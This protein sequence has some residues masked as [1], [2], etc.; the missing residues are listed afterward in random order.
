VKLQGFRGQ[1]SGSIRVDAAAGPVMREFEFA[2]ASTRALHHI[3]I[4]L[5]F[6]VLVLVLLQKGGE[7]EGLYHATLQVCMSPRLACPFL[8]M[9]ICWAVYTRLADTAKP[10]PTTDSLSKDNTRTSCCATTA[11]NCAICFIS[12]CPTDLA[13]HSFNMPISRHLSSRRYLL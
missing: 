3:R 8:V 10:K 13:R 1:T 11:S 2:P 7:G 12:T 5:D 9:L 6:R 4:L